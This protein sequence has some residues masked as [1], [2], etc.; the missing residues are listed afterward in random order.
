MLRVEYQGDFTAWYWGLM[1][2]P[3]PWDAQELV[4]ALWGARADGWHWRSGVGGL[5]GTPA[6]CRLCHGGTWDESWN[7]RALNCTQEQFWRQVVGAAQNWARQHA[8]KH[9]LSGVQWWDLLY[10]VVWWLF[11][12]CHA[13]VVFCNGQNGAFLWCKARQ[14]KQSFSLWIRLTL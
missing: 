10:E 5:H 4:G 7:K 8:K 9:D 2:L 6:W 3:A 12:T 14:S 11:L 13:C 1:M